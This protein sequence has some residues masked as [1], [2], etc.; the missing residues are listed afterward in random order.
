MQSI[1]RPRSQRAR[2][3]GRLVGAFVLVVLV[4]TVT[5]YYWSPGVALIGC[6]AIFL[7]VYRTIKAL[8]A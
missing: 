1:S 8:D 6:G 2:T 4:A 7:I 5:D 3:I